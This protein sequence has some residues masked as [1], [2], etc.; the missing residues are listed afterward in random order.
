MT[1]PREKWGMNWLDQVLMRVRE[2]I[3]REGAM[4]KRTG[5]TT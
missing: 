4:M 5:T 1:V 3:R 2:T